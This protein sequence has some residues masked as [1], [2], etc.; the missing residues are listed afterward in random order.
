MRVAGL[1]WVGM[2]SPAMAAAMAAEPPVRSYEGTISMPTYEPGARELEPSLFANSTV[3]GMYPFPSYVLPWRAG[4]PAPRKYRAIFVEN[5]Y[6]KITYLPEMGGR[7]FSLYDK[8]RKREVFYRNDV[9]KPAPYNPRMSWPQSG[10]ELTGPHDVH[11]LTLHG[12]PFWSNRI[13][14]LAEEA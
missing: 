9:I 2:A 8:I 4:S 14:R 10:L 11:M 12:E 13:V 1:A 5:E 7:I 6:L 3:G